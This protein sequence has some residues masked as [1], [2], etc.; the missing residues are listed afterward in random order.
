M[1]YNNINNNIKR[2][3][4]NIDIITLMSFKREGERVRKSL[5]YNTKL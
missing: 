1:L 4:R 5:I 3:K 2:V